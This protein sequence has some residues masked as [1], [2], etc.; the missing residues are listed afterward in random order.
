MHEWKEFYK[1]LD[2]FPFL[3]VSKIAFAHWVKDSENSLDIF[4]IIIA[5]LKVLK[6]L[7]TKGWTDGRTDGK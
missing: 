5:L 4:P 7:S 3:V 1:V 2:L 6:I